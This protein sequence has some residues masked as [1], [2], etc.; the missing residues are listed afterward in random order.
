MADETIAALLAIYPNRGYAVAASDYLARME[1]EHELQ[2]LGM[3]LVISDVNGKLTVDEIGA[4][5]AGRG[6]KRGLA[7]G[8]V[9]GLIFPPSIIATSIAGAAAGGLFGKL[10]GHRDRHEGLRV[11]GE[12]LP[13]G[14][15]GIVALVDESQ[16]DSVA[17]HLT[18][19]EDL[20]RAMVNK[21]TL[22]VIDDAADQPSA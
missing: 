1:R 9:A 4:P 5:S 13:Q 6:A 8:A 3:A 16:V 17:E 14:H 7:A 22:E 10:R 12:R 19:Y 21:T 2:I 18:G 15:A 20:Q 11:L